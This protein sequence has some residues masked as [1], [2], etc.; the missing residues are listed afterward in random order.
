MS[1][2]L[3]DSR[4]FKSKKWN[5]LS[6]HF[7]RI[8]YVGLLV[9]ADP[10]GR[11][12]ADAEDLKAEIFAG[13]G[14]NETEEIIE[15]SLLEL[16][17]TGLINYYFDDEKVYYSIIRFDDFQCFNEK[18]RSSKSK[19]PSSQEITVNH[20]E[21]QYRLIIKHKTNI[22]HKTQNILE[23]NTMAPLEPV[24]LK[25]SFDGLEIKQPRST[26]QPTPEPVKEKYSAILETWNN[27]KTLPSHKFIN[28]T[29]I[30]LIQKRL[31][32][33]FAENEIIEAIEN[34]GEVLASDKYYFTHKWTLELFIKQANALP[35]FVT[36][37]DPKTNYL[38]R[39]G[40]TPGNNKQTYSKSLSAAEQTKAAGAELIKSMGL[41]ND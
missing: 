38:V 32:K 25:N 17:Q 5:N 20:C 40:Q 27:Q 11:G 37:S 18:N 22:K 8:V 24:A 30:K 29:T 4:I 34:Y 6:S 16:S 1:R 12:E 9:Y 21:S 2:R 35:M 14:F 36:A 3:V 33:E 31:K 15:N 10:H 13:R 41:K 39:G 19:F 23:K 28:D 7:T 26:P